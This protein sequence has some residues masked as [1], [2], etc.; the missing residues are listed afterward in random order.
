MTDIPGA[1]S[2][3]Q[4]AP[5]LRP[6][7]VGDILS[8]SFTLIRQN[9]PATIGLTAIG[10]AAGAVAAIVLVLATRN[11]AAGAAVSNLAGFVLD[12]AI[13]VVAGAVIAALGEGL[14]GRRITV[15]EAFRRARIGWVLLTWLV[16]AVIVVVIWVI[17]L[18]LLS[19]LGVL[20]GLPLWVWLGIMLCLIFPVVVLERRNPFAAIGRSWRLV[21]GSFWRFFAIS[22][23]MSIVT[24]ALFA[25]ATLFV[26]LV[27]GVGL[28]LLREHGRLHGS[29]GLVWLVTF[30]V[31]ALVLVSLVAPMWLALSC[32]LY[33]DVRMRREGMDLMLRLPPWQGGPAG[34][35]FAATAPGI[36]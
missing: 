32:L 16:Y 24:F 35:E 34:D 10:T 21:L 14:L 9:P 13:I 2:G 11:S 25:I 8:A 15:R 22:L 19:G 4:S 23:L 17:P 28:T 26:T 7:G 27:T 33:A 18:I 29:F 6:L 1:Q 30:I 31:F 20:L 5:Q 12:T 3:G 36:R